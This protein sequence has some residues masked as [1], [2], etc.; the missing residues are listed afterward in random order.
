MNR[1]ARQRIS[2]FLSLE[3]ILSPW[4][5]NGEVETDLL[6]RT[7]LGN[8]WRHWGCH[9]LGW[10]CSRHLVVRGKVAAEYPT[11]SSPQK[12]IIQPQMSLVPRFFFKKKKK[13]LN[14]RMRQSPF[15]RSLP[16]LNSLLFQIHEMGESK[17]LEE[18]NRRSSKQCLVHGESK[19]ER[20][21]SS[22][23]SRSLNSWHPF[24]SQCLRTR[25]PTCFWV[26]SS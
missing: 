14:L 19:N 5:S 2:S 11:L 7:T 18:I 10:G 21:P 6:P 9:S 22:G 23:A 12:R 16:F 17:K 25:L 15:L 4:P 8:I 13:N 26:S 24:H 20:I 1:I 3:F